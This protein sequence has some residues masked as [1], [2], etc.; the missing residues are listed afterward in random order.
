MLNDRNGG[1][2][3]MRDELVGLCRSTPSVPGEACDALASWD[4]HDRA[5][6]RGAL[7]FRRFAER[8]V[9]F[10]VPGPNAVGGGAP[11]AGTWSDAFDVARPVD[12]PEQLN[13]GNPKAALAL[14]DAVS[15]LRGAG[16]PFDAP[17]GDW[18]YEQRGGERI[19]WHGGPGDVGVFNAY[20][21]A[22]DPQRGYPD[23]VHGG[24]FL[25]ASELRGRA[26]RRA[27][28]SATRSPPTARSPWHVDQ[29]R[30]L[31][32]REWVTERYCE[33]Q[34]LRSPALRASRLGC[35]PG[36]AGGGG[37]GSPSSGRA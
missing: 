21:N 30:M 13:T 35:L 28:L 19:A 1:A 26:R 36:T 33:S 4:A 10:P 2:E 5:E 20:V 9:D 3:L 25:M 7:L 31:A 37:A 23:V 14:S 12:T 8:F 17:L 16:I 6:S 24:S 18:Q 27:R 22:W 15:D 11:P 32:R 34:V 29:T